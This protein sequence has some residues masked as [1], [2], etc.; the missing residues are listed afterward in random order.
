MVAASQALVSEHQTMRQW[1][2]V[3]YIPSSCAAALSL[4]LTELEA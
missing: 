2:F 4:A 3:E 1:E